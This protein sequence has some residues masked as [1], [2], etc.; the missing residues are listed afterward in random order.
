MPA[1]GRIRSGLL[2]LPV[3]L[4]AA[5]ACERWSP[6]NPI[7]GVAVLQGAHATAPCAACHDVNTPFTAEVITCNGLKVLP[8]TGFDSAD[9][10][11]PPAIDWTL[12]C[13]ECHECNRPGP[14]SGT[15]CGEPVTTPHYGTA[16]C[17]AGDGC[18][19]FADDSWNQD[20]KCGG[21]TVV[22]NTCQTCHEQILG[23]DFENSGAPTVG[24][25]PA[26]LNTAIDTVP[27]GAGGFVGYSCD[28]C[29]PDGGFGAATH[30]D[31]TLDLV[32][33]AG[34][35]SFGTYDVGT[36]SCT[37]SCHGSPSVLTYSAPAA[38]PVWDVAGTGCGTC[39]G[40]PPIAP[41]IDIQQCAGCHTPTGGPDPNAVVGVDAHIDGVL[42]CTAGNCP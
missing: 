12:Q 5:T 21:T 22:P 16:S 14:G 24:S 4:L 19:S 7:E 3:A 1:G 23:G 30:D 34:G 8:G 41:H 20:D 11:A 17:G 18:H 25:H 29:H 40:S 37:V 26:H 36:N 9:T 28:V 13:L 6:R 31:G 35:T 39:H 42:Q 2:A 32:M 38:L 10:A 33:D 15:V 27:D